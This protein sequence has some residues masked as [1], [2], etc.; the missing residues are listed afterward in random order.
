M[1]LNTVLFTMAPTT[2]V[3]IGFPWVLSIVGVA[4]SRLILNLR[5]K[6][7][8]NISGPSSLADLTFTIPSHMYSAVDFEDPDSIATTTIA[9]TGHMDAD[10]ED[11]DSDGED[12]A[13]NPSRSNTTSSH[14]HN[15]AS[16]RPCDLSDVESAPSSSN[17]G[18]PFSPRTRLP[19]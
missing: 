9:T 8:T 13:L 5:A 6:H 16:I 1:L 4:G 15:Y 7:A 18:S 17:P 3:L 12:A 11:S 10:D 14:S 19:S 2:L